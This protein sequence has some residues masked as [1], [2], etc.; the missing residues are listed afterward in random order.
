MQ[1]LTVEFLILRVWLRPSDVSTCIS[2]LANSGIT[3]L[4]V[5]N[6]MM[7]NVLSTAFSALFI[8]I[9]HTVNKTLQYFFTYKGTKFSTVPHCCIY[10]F[11]IRCLSIETPCHD[12]LLYTKFRDHISVVILCC[13]IAAVMLHLHSNL[14]NLVNCT[15]QQR[16]T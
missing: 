4:T 2:S 8:I 3:V 5:E 6:I 10:Y 1:Y 15:R 14:C 7:N 9:F 11:V 12:H 16:Y 13:I